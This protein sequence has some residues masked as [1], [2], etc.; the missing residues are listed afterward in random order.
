[1]VVAEDPELLLLD[2]PTAGMTTRET[3][4]TQTAVL[5]QK[6]AETRTVLVIDHDMDFVELLDA[7][8]SVL[9]QGRVLTEGSLSVVRANPKVISVYLGRS[10]EEE[11]AED[12]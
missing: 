11:V 1:M 2:E 5:I 12:A 8:V 3:A 6:L 7:P 10:A 9:H 4:Q